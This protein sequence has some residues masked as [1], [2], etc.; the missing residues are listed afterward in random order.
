MAAI[1]DP[2]DLRAMAKSAVGLSNRQAACA[3]IIDE[4]KRKHPGHIRDDIP[5]L[6]NNSGGAMGEMKI[7]HF[8]LSEYLLLYGTPIGTGGHSGRYRTQLWDFVFDGEMWSYEEGEL[9][10]T[11]FE[12]GGVSYLGKGRVKGWG[13][14]HAAFMLEYA[15][16]PVVTMLPFGLADSAFSTVD[17]P[18]LAKQLWYASRLTIGELLKGKV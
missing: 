16:G 10:R 17:M 4:L 14:P 6:F 15:R 11:V 3:H 8:S 18:T 5:W 1:F 7:L 13:V 2:D 9:E 12:P